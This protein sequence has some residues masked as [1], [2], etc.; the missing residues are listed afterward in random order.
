VDDGR[1]DA[2]HERAPECAETA[3]ADNDQIGVALACQ[4]DDLVDSVALECDGIAGD[5]GLLRTLSRL[6]EHL[7]RAAELLGQ[8]PLIVR[9][10]EHRQ[11]GGSDGHEGHVRADRLGE[12][13]AFVDRDPAA[14]RSVGRDQDQVL[15]LHVAHLHSRRRIESLARRGIRGPADPVCGKAAK[16]PGR[17]ADAGAARTT[18]GSVR[19]MAVTSDSTRSTHVAD[20]VLRDGSTMRLRPPVAADEDELVSFFRGLSDHSLYLR[21][22]G[23][24]RVD[25]GLVVPVLDPDWHDRG[26][27][28]G[29]AA[30]RVV[31][32]ASYVRL[33]DVRSA[34]VAFAVA[35]EFQ[36]RGIATRMLEQLAASAAQVGIEEF[37]AEVLA[38]ND[39]MLRVF[40]DAGFEVT[41]ATSWGES[42]VRLRLAPTDTYRAHVDG[43]DHVAVAAS[44]RPFFAPASVAVVGASVR[45]GSIGGELFRNVLRAEFAGVAYPVNRTAEAVAG[46]QGYASVADIP[47]SVDLAVIC[48]PGPAVLAAAEDALAA[49][50]RALCVISAGFAETGADGIARQERLLE[51]VRAHGAR[52]L[53]PNCLGIAVSGPRLNATFGPRALPAGHVGFSSQSGALGLALLERAD[54]RGLGLASFVSIGNKADVSS[55]D[56]LEYW[57]DDDETEVIVLYLESFGNPRKFARV[58]QRVA[59]TKPIVAMK[60]G[61][62]ATGARA[63]SSHTAALAGSEAAVDALFH[64]TG[65]LRVETLE[66]LL[67]VTSLLAGQ[68]LPRGR[69]VAVLT[70]AGG[71]GILCADACEAAGL[72]L[73]ELAPATRD[74]LGAVLPVEASLA[75]PVDML[76]SATAE[77][78]ERVLPVLLADPGIDA[79][80]VLFVPPVV[81]GAEEVAAA[82]T[83]A[84]EGAPRQ[85]KPVLASVISAGGTPAAL[86][87]GAATQFAYPES[88]ARSLGRVAERAEWLRRPRGR[89]PAM[90]GI[91]HE[92]AWAVVAD[93]ADRW[94]TPAETRRLLEAYSLPL[95]AERRAESVDAAVAAAGELGFPVVVKSAVPGAHKTEI[96][97]VALDLRDEEAVREAAGRI[98]APL[99]VQAL[100]RGGVEL[101]VGAVNDPVFGPLV[102]LGPGGTFAELIGDAGFRLAPLTDVDA[103]E[104]VSAGKAGLLV[105][106]FRGAPASD[107][108]AVADVVLRIGRL[109]A[110]IPEIAEIDLNPVIA[111]PD[112][113]VAVDARVRCAPVSPRRDV[114]TW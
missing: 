99:L 44:L 87:D 83:R 45:R 48:V 46:V 73:P 25:A 89:V 59:R 88:A 85:D 20:V 7:A 30:G 106:G 14:R 91:D 95:V 92:A 5:V 2:S 62:T 34:E 37:L 93:A 105:D 17:G 16:D 41:R 75:N 9:I 21:F 55:N 6:S 50:V 90:A 84:V 68:P 26:A 10:A 38:G 22:H 80:I 72:A 54:E 58:A 114:K 33:R 100:V 96:G 15:V 108:R 12:R 49:G 64:Q 109:I 110:E 53:G 35:D 11:G 86:R 27:L 98:G 70:N 112:G 1:G 67:D 71:L 94:L 63:A 61:R 77:T 60:A 101:L 103:D 19:P 4:P 78:Y 74:A 3:R 23:H 57:E 97:G 65:V 79:L 8:R 40:A 32:L 29:T 24:P 56:L 51:L 82:I 18:E 36:G 81:A 76:G 69:N 107:R 47:A 102:A 39:A 113:C 52:L 66:E 111:G 42:E 31:A 28:V 43:R 104:L 13:E